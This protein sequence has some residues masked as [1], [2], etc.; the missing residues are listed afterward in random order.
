MMV[1]IWT[2]VLYNI[3]IIIYI[4]FI[5]QFFIYILIRM[6]KWQY[7]L[8]VN[9]MF[10]FHFILCKTMGGSTYFFSFVRTNLTLLEDQW[11]L[12]ESFIIL[13]SNLFLDINPADRWSNNSCMSIIG[14]MNPN[15]PNHY[16]LPLL[17]FTIL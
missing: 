14:S 12:V 8:K 9:S 5:L 13:Q 10:F 7:F 15:S 4:N 6:M 16:L 17:L 11:S 1:I 3:I 2:D